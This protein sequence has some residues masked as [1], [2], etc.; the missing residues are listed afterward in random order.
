M[1]IYIYIYMP[2]YL[3]TDAGVRDGRA[4]AG[5]VLSAAARSARRVP[6]FRE[7]CK[8]H[9]ILKLHR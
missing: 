9:Q 2:W 5:R 3:F 1:C 8:L 4:E 6:I 7:H